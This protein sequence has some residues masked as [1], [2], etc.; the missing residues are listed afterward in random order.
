MPGS[1]SL[2][3]CPGKALS[4]SFVA[5]SLNGE[6]AVTGGIADAHVIGSG[7]KMDLLFHGN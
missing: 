3:R 7:A 4:T 6:L 1:D 5:P 2:F